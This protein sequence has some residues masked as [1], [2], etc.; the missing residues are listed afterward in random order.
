MLGSAGSVFQLEM[1]GGALLKP[2]A[3]GL[4]SAASNATMPITFFGFRSGTRNVL[5]PPAE[6]GSRIAGPISSSSAEIF[7]DATTSPQY[8]AVVELA[9]Q[10]MT[11]GFVG[12]GA[13]PGHT[14]ASEVES[15]EISV[16]F[17]TPTL[18]SRQLGLLCERPWP[19]R[20][21]T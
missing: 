13:P 21:T 9:V 1:T 14:V 15:R 10:P 8:G 11:A 6:C 18:P 19:G 2:G 3:A 12:V 7:C 5:P 4:A 20:S 16:L 17:A